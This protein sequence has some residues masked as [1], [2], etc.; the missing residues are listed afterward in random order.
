MVNS[1]GHSKNNI[2]RI[3]ALYV[4]F[5][6]GR[7]ENNQYYSL[8]YTSQ[9]KKKI[10]KKIHNFK[11]KPT[12]IVDTR[13]GIHVY[14][15]VD[16]CK[17]GEFEPLQKRMIQYFKSDEKVHDLSRVMRL[18]N[19]YWTKDIN[20][21][22]LCKV[23]EYNNIK[24]NINEFDIILPKYKNNINNNN[25]S[26][27]DKN[28]TKYNKKINISINEYPSKNIEYIKKKDWFKL[29]NI[30]INNNHNYSME[31]VPPYSIYDINTL[32]GG[33]FCNTPTR[34]FNYRNKAYEYLR[35]QD[36]NTY[37]GL[38]NSNFNCVIH[39]DQSKSAGIFITEEGNY[40]YK[41]FSSN[42][43]FGV[44]DINKI[45]E[46]LTGLN[47]PDTLKFMMKVFN[48]EIIK[49]D[50]Q[51]KYE[52]MLDANIDLLMDFQYLKNQ[53]PDLYKRIK[54][55]IPQLIIVH[56]CAKRN[57]NLDSFGLD[58]M[59]FI[60]PKR[61]IAQEKLEFEI[62]GKKYK[63]PSNEKDVGLRTNILTYI[64]LINK[65]SDKEILEDKLLE[66]QKFSKKN[67]YSNYPTLYTIPSYDYS[68]LSSAHDKA[69]EFKE[70]NLKIKGFGR[71]MLLRNL[72]ESEANRVFPRLEGKKHFSSNDKIVMILKF[73]ALE[74][75]KD[76]G[77]VIIKDL[78]NKKEIDEKIIE[79]LSLRESQKV[80]KSRKEKAFN[81]CLQE[82]L[83]E[84]LLEYKR[85]N[86]E[87]KKRFNIKD[88][89][90]YPYIIYK[91]N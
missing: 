33:T 32:N 11:L 45:T 38:H 84:Y 58:K 20:N 77:Y 65:V 35:K 87:L 31:K 16:N 76:K 9:Y 63:N 43:K 80:F 46:A 55:Y 19:Y 1:G 49:T 57:I 83:D 17:I 89:K 72:G 39:N 24:Y 66:L 70:K 8:K 71:E 52:E 75:I 88:I 25:S 53:Y 7:N 61:A 18:P 48:I 56:E 2:T 74:E 78:I 12:I 79:E 26:I 60:A 15:K 40:L 13:N 23:I 50:E 81:R 69:I 6:A 91:E 5:D 54:K 64:G 10:L 44:G 22:Y 67:G 47:R 29:R 21:K 28:N 82:F 37:L 36:L 68:T 73:A 51:I 3:N 14:W 85:L 34:I 41:C 90:G 30:M 4:D 62:D 59:V 42:C 27:K 86:K